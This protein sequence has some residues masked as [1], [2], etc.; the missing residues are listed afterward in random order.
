MLS[1]WV[2]LKAINPRTWIHVAMGAGI[3]FLAYHLYSLGIEH[4][5]VKAKNE[6]LADGAAELK[7]QRDDY[8][9]AMQTALDRQHAAEVAASAASAK[10]IVLDNRAAASQIQQGA[11]AKTVAALPDPQL[12]SD[13]V[14]RINQRPTD[15][16]AT[17]LYP[18]ELRTIDASLADLPFV[19]DQLAVAN[20]KA[21]ALIDK[22]ISDEALVAALK[23]ENAATLRYAMA[24][25][26]QYT[27]AYNLA[28]P[29][30]PFIV[31]VFTLGL[32]HP[33]KLNLAPPDAMPV[34]ALV[35]VPR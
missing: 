5:R 18:A 20:S 35:K 30:V 2:F 6:V 23:D 25:H 4:E 32:K 7:K 29:R 16:P 12:F 19:R 31:R 33:K 28:Q 8:S 9:A 21:S 26:E 3:L 1:L 15:D 14:R 27:L 11:T 17:T 10:V 22:S 24:L 13:I 34:P